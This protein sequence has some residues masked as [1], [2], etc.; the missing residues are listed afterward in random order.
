MPT[1]TF[2][3]DAWKYASDCAHSKNF[4]CHLSWGLSWAKRC[5]TNNH[6]AN[7]SEKKRLSLRHQRSVA[8]YFSACQVCTMLGGQVNHEGGTFP[9]INFEYINC[10]PSW[11]KATDSKRYL[12]RPRNGGRQV[13][14][15]SAIPG[16]GIPG[17]VMNSTRK[18][19][20][21]MRFLPAGLSPKRKNTRHWNLL[22]GNHW[23]ES[24]AKW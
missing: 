3:Y 10:L 24:E 22:A 21:F 23:E 2:R 20:Q 16:L 17:L 12:V 6:V 15:L 8:I 4:G 11:R 13:T 1:A 19:N 14:R 18:P 7:T 5:F 9:N